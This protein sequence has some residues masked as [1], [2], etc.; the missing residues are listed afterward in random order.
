MKSKVSANR[1]MGFIENERQNNENAEDRCKVQ[2]STN[3]RTNSNLGSSNNGQKSSKNFTNPK[4]AESS[5]EEAK[6]L[7]RYKSPTSKKG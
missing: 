6:V 4:V 5:I 7:S 3:E 2:S 1:L